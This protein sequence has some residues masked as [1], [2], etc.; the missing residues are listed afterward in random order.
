[1]DEQS[2][3]GPTMNPRW[4]QL[5]MSKDDFKFPDFTDPFCR[6]NNLSVFPSNNH[7]CAFY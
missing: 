5:E 6:V 4:S 1:M 3:T 7:Q 2:I